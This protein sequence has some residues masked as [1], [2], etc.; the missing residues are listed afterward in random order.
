MM[1]SEKHLDTIRKYSLLE[2]LVD[3]N[4]IV[5]EQV[6]DKL[7]LNVR[8][9]LETGQETDRELLSLCL[10]V[11]YNN[12]MKAFGLNQLMK[13][14]DKWKSETREGVEE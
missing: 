11:V 4:G 14:Y 13:L 7:K 8:S 1:I 5:D 12:N 10:D 3:S 9:M 2:N 6:L